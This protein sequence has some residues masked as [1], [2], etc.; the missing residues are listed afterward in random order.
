[1]V[2]CFSSTDNAM[3]LSYFNRDANFKTEN[4][5]S[6]MSS[7][8]MFD[9]DNEDDKKN[10]E[11]LV[12]ERSV[13]VSPKKP[14]QADLMINSDNNLLAKINKLL[15]GVPPPPKL[16]ICRTDCSELL[17]RIYENQHLFW[18]QCMLSDKTTEEDINEESP[19]QQKENIS[20]NNYQYTKSTS[21]NLSTAF[22][23]CD[24]INNIINNIDT[25]D[26]K[27]TCSD[28]FRLKKVV[29]NN[30]KS[31]INASVSETKFLNPKEVQESVT[32]NKIK[33]QSES[34]QSLL[35]YTVNEKEAI[36]L[37]WPEA[38]HHK[39]HGI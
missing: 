24:S 33:Q 30:E 22:D 34:K 35:Y 18:T 10:N 21:R 1:M 14:S 4:E 26:L 5:L 9:S 20:T 36:T 13:V 8:E 16:T 2:A 19:E 25:I 12:T 39:F 23:A 28:N 6:N 29:P 3:D 7:P 31:I 11:P 32:E 38:Y 27:D 15:S 17:S 37:T